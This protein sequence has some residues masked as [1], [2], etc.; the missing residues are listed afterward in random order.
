MTTVQPS[1]ASSVS[2]LFKSQLGFSAKHPPKTT[3]LTGKVVIVTGGN[4][5]LG[6]ESARQFLGFKA[7][8]VI[9]AS[10][11]DAKGK[12][13]VAKLKSEFPKA[14]VEA[15]P[16]DMLSYDSIQEFVKTVQRELSRLDIVVLNAGLRKIGFG[17]S[18]L[19]GHEEVVQVNYISTVL[20]SV[21][22]LPILKERSPSG[23]P[24]RLTIVSSG[25]VLLHKF[26]NSDRMPF[27]KSFNDV[28]TAPAPGLPNYAASKAMGHMFAA[29]IVE[30]VSS[31]DVIINLADPGMTRGTEFLREFPRAALIL[32]APLLRVI[33][34]SVRDGASTYL[35][36]TLV[37]GPESH[38][39]FVMDWEVRPY[40]DF[41]YTEAGKAT[42]EK[43]WAE[44]MDE[45]QGY[46]LRGLLDSMKK[47][48][49]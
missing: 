26:P 15:W 37:K 42:T 36:A 1:I 8:T 31:D 48:A 38:G 5:G 25:I 20:L 34:R 2:I 45:F 12:E 11:S 39:R 9:I 18:E 7:S 41:L 10:R 22:L 44:T 24:G 40:A 30:Y 16:L 46:N 28:A 17:L 33:T 23:T 21:L 29:K 19:T 14:R 43:L 13:A 47:P 27:L 4:T 3:D 35:D 32:M 6:F 49:P